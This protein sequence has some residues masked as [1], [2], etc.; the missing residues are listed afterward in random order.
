MKKPA[1]DIQNELNELGS[2]LSKARKEDPEIPAGYFEQLEN[3]ILEKT[4]F[5][6]QEKSRI[7]RITRIKYAASIAAVFAIVFIGIRF[8]H[9]RNDQSLAMQFAKMSDAEL[10]TYLTNQIA[11]ISADDLH[12]YITNNIN[13]IEAGLFAETELIDNETMNSRLN[14][15]VN[16]QILSDEDL[17]NENNTPL[18]DQKLLDQIDEETI[19]QLL[20]DESMF[21]DFAL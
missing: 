9:A 18:L 16:L 12:T 3:E 2:F 21:D 4:I 14:S 17:N 10:D 13:E 20:N 7:I 6:K 8:Y 5:G 11:S 19:E 15:E 1:D